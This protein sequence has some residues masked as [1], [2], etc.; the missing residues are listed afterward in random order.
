MEEKHWKGLA[1]QHPQTEAV[2]MRTNGF[3]SWLEEWQ[4]FF[5]TLWGVFPWDFVTGCTE[6]WMH[7]FYTRMQT[8]FSGHPSRQRQCSKSKAQVGHI[9]HIPSLIAMP[10]H[11]KPKACR[12]V[13]GGRLWQ[14]L[15]PARDK[16]SQRFTNDQEENTS[17]GWK[18][19]TSVL[20]RQV[21]YNLIKIKDEK[22][23]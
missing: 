5:L 21:I 9:S 14:F 1:T 3:E 22:Y 15:K 8:H 23:I 19:S 12:G 2:P 18:Q 6:G 20:K 10:H 4:V 16:I 7:Y 13:R 17:C 11:W